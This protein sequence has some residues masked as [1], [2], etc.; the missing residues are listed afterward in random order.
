MIRVKNIKSVRLDDASHRTLIQNYPGLSEFFPKEIDLD[1]LEGDKVLFF[2]RDKT[3]GSVGAFLSLGGV[4]KSGSEDWMKIS[5]LLDLETMQVSG[6]EV[7][8][9]VSGGIPGVLGTGHTFGPAMASFKHPEKEPS[10]LGFAGRKVSKTEVLTELA[11]YAMG[12]RKEA[13]KRRLNS[14]LAECLS[15][16]TGTSVE[17][18]EMQFTDE[19]NGKFICAVA[20]RAVKIARHVYHIENFEFSLEERADDGVHTRICVKV[21]EG[22]CSE[23]TEC[24]TPY[25]ATNNANREEDYLGSVSCKFCCERDHKGYNIPLS[26]ILFMAY[27]EEIVNFYPVWKTEYDWKNQTEK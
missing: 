12:E 11:R 9:T 25:S 13:A 7:Q 27:A 23:S 20:E 6:K 22:D 10:N 17:I 16:V 18:C 21:G 3:N 1:A 26:R 2:P 15:E 5:L 19:K 24:I 8:S 14:E 4:P